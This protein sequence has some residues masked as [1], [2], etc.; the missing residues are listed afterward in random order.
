[1]PLSL[2]VALRPAVVFTLMV[3][4]LLLAGCSREAV[5]DAMIAHERK[6]AGLLDASMEVDQHT[7]A[8]LH[9]Q[10]PVDGPDM[11]L[12][13]GFAA[14][15]ENWLGMAGELT[16]HYNVYAID[17]PGHGASDKDL[18]RDYTIGAQTGYVKAIL[19]ALELD[20]V[21]MVGNSMGGAI[22][23]QFAA[24]YPDRVLTA[25]L[26]DPAGVMVYDSELVERVEAGDNPLIVERPGDFEKLVDFAMERKPFVPWPIYSVMEDHAL[27]NR[28]INHR[29][30]SQ[31][32]N[33][34]YDPAFRERLAS[35]RAPVLIIWG[36]EDRVID[37]RNADIFETRIP[38]AR[39]VILDDVGHVPM[40]EVPERTAALVQGFIQ[41][42]AG[43]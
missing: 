10:Y 15:K 40:I 9:N 14:N 5:Y 35:I 22:T 18:N 20:R 28:A 42:Q 26:L 11:V 37:Y 4:T 34:G 27:A 23:A 38:H 21:H 31:I 19:D 12:L 6:A 17:L 13:H 41:D 30:F 8:Y 43:N 29:I 33:S 39:K 3:C 1:M 36:R 24:T 25:T 2:S 16:D 7:V 32:E